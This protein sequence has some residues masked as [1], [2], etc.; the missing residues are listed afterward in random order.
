MQDVLQDMQ[1][2]PGQ[3]EV[4]QSN[5]GG[6]RLH[7]GACGVHD[8]NIECTRMMWG[9]LQQCR[10]TPAASRLCRMH[11]HRVHKD[12]AVCMRVM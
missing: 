3:C 4:H 9:A 11:Q 1:D 12:D 5:I 6:C 2:S 10:T 8:G 7:Y